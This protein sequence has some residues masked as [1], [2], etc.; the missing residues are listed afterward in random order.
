MKC[1]SFFMFS[2]RLKYL[3]IGINHI[4]LLSRKTKKNKHHN[5]LV[6]NLLK[7]IG[8]FNIQ[9]LQTLNFEH[10]QQYTNKET[11][12]EIH[13]VNF[14]YIFLILITPPPKDLTIKHNLIYL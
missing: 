5:P 2:S 10:S 4:N 7:I 3:F 14:Y 9:K 1:S 11:I 12:R 8:D 6:I 13:I